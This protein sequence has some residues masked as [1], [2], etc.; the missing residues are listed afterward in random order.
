MSLYQPTDVFID[1]KL[2]YY[3]GIKLIVK[4]E[5]SLSRLHKVQA[6][7]IKLLFVSFVFIAHYYHDENYKIFTIYFIL[8]FNLFDLTLVL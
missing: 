4:L 6:M 7:H 3:K 5:I 2:T 1:V 8:Y